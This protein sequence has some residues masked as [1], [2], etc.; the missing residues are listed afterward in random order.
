VAKRRQ[1]NIRELPFNNSAVIE[2]E[3]AVLGGYLLG[4]DIGREITAGIF[5]S[6]ANGIVFQTI[7]KMK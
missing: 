6:G 4:A 5:L 1:D 2:Y 7:V 3:R